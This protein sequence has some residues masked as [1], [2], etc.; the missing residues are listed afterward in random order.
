MCSE[1]ERFQEREKLTSRLKYSVGSKR[2][3]PLACSPRKVARLLRLLRLVDE[4]VMRNTW[5]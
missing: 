4:A 5:A 2:M 3:K 1:M